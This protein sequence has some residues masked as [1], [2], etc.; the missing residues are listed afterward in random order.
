MEGLSRSS[1]V[2]RILPFSISHPLCSTVYRFHCLIIFCCFVIQ[3]LDWVVTL[4]NSKLRSS[5]LH[6]PRRFLCSFLLFRGMY[7]ISEDLG[8]VTCSQ[9]PGCVICFSVPLHT[10]SGQ[11]WQADESGCCP[12]WSRAGPDRAGHGVSPWLDPL[13]LGW[14]SPPSLD[15]HYWLRGPTRGA[16]WANT[17]SGPCHAGDGRKPLSESQSLLYYH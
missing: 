17:P 16:E 13:P 1:E 10:G 4:K 11:C 15:T 2:F 5:Y 7:F 9:V 14:S 6:T 3:F 8:D 12:R